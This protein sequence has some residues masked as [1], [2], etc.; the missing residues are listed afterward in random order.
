MANLTVENLTEVNEFL[1]KHNYVNG[2]LPGADDVRLF[3]G[4]KGRISILWNLVPPKDK[5]P[6]VYFWYLLLSSFTPAV[7]E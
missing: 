5:F 2:D 1:A 7:R 3:N 6:E 4:L